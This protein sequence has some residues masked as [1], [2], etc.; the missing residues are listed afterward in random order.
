MKILLA[1]DG[2]EYTQRMLTW[3]A[4]HPEVMGAKPELDILTVTTPLPV[5]VARY[6]DKATED[7]YYAEQANGVLTPVEEF[8]RAYGW[9]MNAM[10]AQGPAEKR[11]VEKADA[12]AYDMLVMGS[13]GHSALGNV[14]LGSVTQR[15]LATS[16]VP[17]LIVR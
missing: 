11:I 1:V 16:K 2:S 3:L 9:K 8:C 17:V 12:G 4:A 15:V 13:Q 10:S 5:H 6:L 14:F 7:G